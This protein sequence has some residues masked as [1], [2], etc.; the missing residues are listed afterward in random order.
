V[1]RRP[2]HI[3]KNNAQNSYDDTL[4]NHSTSNEAWTSRLR[5]LPVVMTARVR[6]NNDVARCD[7]DITK[8]PVEHVRRQYSRATRT[9][10]SGMFARRKSQHASM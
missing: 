5:K 10:G 6:I 2:R 4:S 3:G 9:A 8:N 7:S 1:S